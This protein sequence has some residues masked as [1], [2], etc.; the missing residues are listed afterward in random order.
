M[1]AKRGTTGTFFRDFGM[2][3]PW[4]K[5]GTRVSLSWS[6]HSTNCASKAGIKDL[7]FNGGPY[8]RLAFMLNTLSSLNIEIIII[9]IL[10]LL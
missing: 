3:L 5:P 9:I 6:E 2:L 1:T 7:L 10:L 4:I 8:G